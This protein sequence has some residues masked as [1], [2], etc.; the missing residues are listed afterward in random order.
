MTTEQI[1]NKM[2]E[3]ILSAESNILTPQY[4]V[5]GNVYYEKV[6]GSCIDELQDFLVSVNKKIY[7]SNFRVLGLPVERIDTQYDIYL[8]CETEGKLVKIK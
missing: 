7:E 4:F 3:L 6:V 8:I 5:L 1:L 2:Y